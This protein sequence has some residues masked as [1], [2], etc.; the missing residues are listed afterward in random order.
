MSPTSLPKGTEVGCIGLD[1]YTIKT[2]SLKAEQIQL[3][4]WPYYGYSQEVYPWNEMEDL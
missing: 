3:E 2:R 4:G 1:S